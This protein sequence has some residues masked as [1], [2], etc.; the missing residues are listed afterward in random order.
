[1][2]QRAQITH[3]PTSDLEPHG[4]EDHFRELFI[5]LND[6][7]VSPARQLSLLDETYC[8]MARVSG[9]RGGPGP[10]FAVTGCDD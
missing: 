4:V 3:D 6:G 5:G 9:S 7:I 8:F 10:S 2:H 1:M